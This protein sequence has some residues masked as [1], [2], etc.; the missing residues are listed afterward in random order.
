MVACDSDD[1]FDDDG[2]EEDEDD[3]MDLKADIAKKRAALF[4]GVNMDV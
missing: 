3:G 4:E 2:E 1:E